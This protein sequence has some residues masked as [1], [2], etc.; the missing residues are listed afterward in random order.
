[1]RVVIDIYEYQYSVADRKSVK[2]WSREG[3]VE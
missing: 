3:D 1:M 2:W